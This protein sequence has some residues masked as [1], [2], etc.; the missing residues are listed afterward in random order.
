MVNT[1]RRTWSIWHSVISVILQDGQDMW[2]IRAKWLYVLYTSWKCMTCRYLVMTNYILMNLCMSN[3]AAKKKRKQYF[4]KNGQLRCYRPMASSVSWSVVV[5]IHLKRTLCR[6]SWSLRPKMFV[7]LPPEPPA[8]EKKLLRQQHQT[9]W[10]VN[11]PPLN[12]PPSS[13]IRD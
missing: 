13:E 6:H 7:A 10:L 3:I 11:Q 9:S 5:H 4:L 1:P 2:R 12:V 8:G